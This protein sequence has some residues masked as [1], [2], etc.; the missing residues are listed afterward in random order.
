MYEKAVAQFPQQYNYLLDFDEITRDTLRTKPVSGIYA[1]LAITQNCFQRLLKLIASKPASCKD[2]IN[3]EIAL[4]SLNWAQ[5]QL[6]MTKEILN[7]VKLQLISANHL[8]NNKF[9]V[10]VQIKARPRN[11]KN[12][13]I[14]NGSYVHFGDA[15]LPIVRSKRHIYTV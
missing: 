9:R 4:I 10:L 8:S 3:K 2:L 13:T 6:N 1:M 14:R 5:S 12:L 7:D 15:K 11:I